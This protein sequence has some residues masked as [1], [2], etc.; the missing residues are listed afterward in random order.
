ML[1]AFAA[2]VVVP[3]CSTGSSSGE[4]ASSTTTS[5]GVPSGAG[6]GA[7]HGGSPYGSSMS[8]EV[9]S[10]ADVTE[11]GPG[12]QVGQAFGGN[13]GLNVCGRF[14]EPPAPVAPV[15]GASVDGAG[16]FTVA[17]TGATGAGHAATVGEVA[18][19]AGVDLAT[20]AV[21]L[22]PS[23]RPVQVDLGSGGA[24]VAVAGR[25]LRS[26]DRCGEDRATVQLWVYTKDAV[27]TGRAVRLVVTDPER[28][29]VVE[30]GMAF[31]IAFSPESSLPT[32]PPSVLAG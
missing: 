13:L 11:L 8:P 15:G 1:V 25:T 10:V 2:A 9:V 31:V 18:R 5:A 3:G 20:G 17:P 23:T 27:E 14:L 29:P 24:P 32:L 30:D 4:G 7:G 22:P 16:R 21:T 12:P 19:A 26:G 6:K 28:T